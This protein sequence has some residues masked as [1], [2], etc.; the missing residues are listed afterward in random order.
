MYVSCLRDLA[1]PGRALALG[2][3]IKITVTSVVFTARDEVLLKRKGSV[4]NRNEFIIT[5]DRSELANAIY[6]RA[7]EQERTPEGV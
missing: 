5:S 1:Q 3:R 6:C 4:S 7:Y 2:S